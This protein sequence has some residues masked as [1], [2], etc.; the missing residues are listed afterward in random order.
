VKLGLCCCG[1]DDPVPGPISCQPCPEPRLTWSVEIIVSGIIMDAAGDGCIDN[2]ADF[3][4]PNCIAGSCGRTRYRRKAVGNI[5]FMPE[6]CGDLVCANIKDQ[7][8]P[9]YAAELFA[10]WSWCPGSPD[11]PVC[12]GVFISNSTG[13]PCGPNILFDYEGP[14]S[15]FTVRPNAYWS[16]ERCRRETPFPNDDCCTLI[17]VDFSYSDYFQYPRVI[18]AS[19]TSDS[20]IVVPNAQWVTVSGAWRCTYGRRVRPGELYAEGAYILLKCEYPGAV[21]T[22]TS[23]SPFECSLP[24]GIAC[25]PSWYLGAQVPT[26]WKP[27]ATIFLERAP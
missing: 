6:E 2:T 27:P 14:I 8:A 9:Y 25:A 5:E 21:S 4:F 15:G 20:C 26:I 10:Q 3:L 11:A 22:Y 7:A 16:F 19:P 13:D 18:R 12:S 1:G 23:V 24:G 17:T